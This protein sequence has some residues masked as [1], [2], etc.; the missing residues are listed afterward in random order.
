MI[1]LFS[2]YIGSSE[3]LV[4]LKRTIWPYGHIQ[5]NKIR[6][7]GKNRTVFILNLITSIFSRIRQIKDFINNFHYLTRK[8][9]TQTRF[10]FFFFDH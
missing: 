8:F 7:W 9:G 2:K 3:N 10:K 5:I 1:T 4:A 6:F